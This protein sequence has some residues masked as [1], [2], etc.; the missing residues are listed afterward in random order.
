MIPSSPNPAGGLSMY[1][2]LALAILLLPTLTVAQEAKPAAPIPLTQPQIVA[3][4]K[5]PNQ[6]APIPTTTIFTPTQTGLYRLSIYATISKADPS[7][8]S[9]WIY[10][11]QY[12]DDSG[13]QILYQFLWGYNNVP[14]QFTVYSQL[15]QDFAG[16][17]ITFE[18]KAGTPVSHSLTLS[19]P[20]DNS[21]YSLYYTLERLE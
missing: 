6:T 2:T 5:L 4:G 17:T 10:N 13:P 1:K 12:T 21:A 8:G 9:G 16:P 19:G 7:S 3:K 18:A 14:G 20:P 11:L 15:F